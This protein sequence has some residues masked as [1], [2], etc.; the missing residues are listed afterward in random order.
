MAAD[1]GEMAVEQPSSAELHAVIIRADGRR[2]DLGVITASYRN[3]LRQWWW[4][5]VRQP[6][7]RRRIRRANR[8]NPTQSSKE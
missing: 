7:A 4:R 6:A 2:E 1:P 8:N 5:L 3:P